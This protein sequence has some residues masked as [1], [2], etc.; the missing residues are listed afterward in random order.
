MVVPTFRRSF[1]PLFFAVTLFLSAFLVFYCEPMVGKMVLPFLGGAPSVWTTCILLFQAM[2]LCGYAYAYLLERLASLRTQLISHLLVM[3]IA[4][5][6]LPIHFDGT[7]QPG[8]AAE[9]PISWLLLRLLLTAAVPFGIAA[10]SAPLLQN[11]LSKTSSAA[12]R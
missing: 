11:W 3:S 10:S 6:F 2:L 9:H 1:V 4:L 12:G 7:A 5:P 8:L